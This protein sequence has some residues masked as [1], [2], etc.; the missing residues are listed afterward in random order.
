MAQI[1]IVITDATGAKSDQA[2][3]PDHEP[4]IRIAAK[5]VELMNMP[6]SGPDGQPM[7][8][9]FHHVATGKQLR[10]NSS[11]ADSGVK[12]GDTLRLI[13]EITAG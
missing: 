13:A 11:L 9:K 12:N 2:T 10:D 3:V 6:L 4:V 5:L 8:Y 1:D 7:S